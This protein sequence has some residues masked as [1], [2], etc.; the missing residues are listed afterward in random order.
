M[1]LSE[2]PG[3]VERPSPLIGEH[4]DLILGKYLGISPE[5]VRQLKAD[6]VL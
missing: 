1:K 5:E 4:N 6:G 3:Q 2:T